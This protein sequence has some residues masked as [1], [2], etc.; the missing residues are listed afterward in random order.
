MM[1]PAEKRRIAIAAPVLHLVIGSVLLAFAARPAELLIPMLVAAAVLPA[2]IGWW[3]F[4]DRPTLSRT[5]LATW[6]PAGEVFLLVLVVLA[7]RPSGVSQGMFIALVIGPLLLLLLLGV[8]ALRGQPR[9]VQAL[10]GGLWA[11]ALAEVVIAV[12]LSERFGSTQ[13]MQTITAIVVLLLAPAA[14]LG[15]WGG[16]A[17]AARVP[18]PVRPNEPVDAAEPSTEGPSAEEP[19]AHE[20]ELK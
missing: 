3:V 6:A 20:G 12:P 11:L 10:V 15:A 1:A 9:K 16:L 2:L 19:T 5:L 8:M 4:T 7:L 14:A 18:E 13:D 17:L